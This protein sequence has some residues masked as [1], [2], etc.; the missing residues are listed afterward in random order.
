VTFHCFVSP[1]LLAL[2]GASEQAPRFVQATLGE[3]VAGKP[4]LMRL[5]PAHLRAD[6]IRPEVW[7]VSWQGS[8]D[9]HANARANCYAVLPPE[10]ERFEAGEVVTVLLR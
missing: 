2:C 4:G 8:G 5:L 3:A 6:R 1:L 10:K 7:I 9:L